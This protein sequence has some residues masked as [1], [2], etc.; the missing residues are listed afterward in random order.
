M[1]R[2]T[3]LQR[4]NITQIYRNEHVPRI[5]WR[6]PFRIGILGACYIFGFESMICEFD[7]GSIIG[8]PAAYLFKPFI[9]NIFP[10]MCLGV[11]FLRY[12]TYE[13]TKDFSWVSVW[14]RNYYYNQRVYT[15]EQLNYYKSWNNMSEIRQIDDS[16]NR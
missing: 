10:L 9:F 3:F 14:Y 7:K 6:T 12:L 2:K 15:K 16:L 13:K 8:A 11:L 4:D 5:N 1:L